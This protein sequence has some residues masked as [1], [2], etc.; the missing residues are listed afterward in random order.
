MSILV[1]QPEHRN[2]DFP[3]A[4]QTREFASKPEQDLFWLRE[5]GQRNKKILQSLLSGEKSTGHFL[6]V[7]DL[8]FL[9]IKGKN[10]K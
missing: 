1:Y 2:T 7:D 6:F 10:K 4:Q 5:Q 3:D 9:D 8:I